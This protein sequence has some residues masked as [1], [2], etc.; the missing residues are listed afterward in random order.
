MLSDVIGLSSDCPKFAHICQ[1]MCCTKIGTSD[2]LGGGVYIYPE[3]LDNKKNIDHLDIRF[4]YPDG[5]KVAVC[6]AKDLQTCDNKYKPYDCRLFPIFPK[7]K[8]ED[9]NIYLYSVKHK[10]GFYC[11]FTEEAALNLVK[12][13][14]PLLFRISLNKTLVNF[15]NKRQ[16]MGYRPLF[17]IKAWKSKL[18]NSQR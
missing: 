6:R 8:G 3:E 13:L 10:D 7:F 15:Y 14:Y 18:S 16:L 17:T 4:N 5:G 9:L 12:I 11:P 1:W 2:H